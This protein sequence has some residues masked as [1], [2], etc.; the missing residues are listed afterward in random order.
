MGNCREREL[1]HPVE[2]I[3][4]EMPREQVDTRPGSC[5]HRGA[6]MLPSPGRV[7]LRVRAAVRSRASL[8][9]W[10]QGLPQKALFWGHQGLTVGMELA[11][12][13]ARV[14]GGCGTTF[15]KLRAPLVAQLAKNLPAMRET[16][17]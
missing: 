17:V 8:R 12:T 10:Q 15:P 11:R 13:G 16:P 9:L 3:P 14:E 2:C 5:Y 7:Q 1:V 6:V 4:E